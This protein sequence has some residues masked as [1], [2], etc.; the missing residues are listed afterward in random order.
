MAHIRIFLSTVSNEFR[1][2]RDR[3]AEK[4]KRPNLSVHVQEDFIAAGTQTLEKLDDYIHECEAV[5]HL[6]G[7][8]TGVMASPSAVAAIKGRYPDIADHFPPLAETVSTGAPVLSY[9]QWEAFLAL[10]HRKILIIA[11]PVAGAPRDP[12]YRKIDAE[13]AA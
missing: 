13:A 11:T 7:D 10:Y 8:M 9:T 4:L 2:Y 5:V 3:L 1:T 12:T 6:V